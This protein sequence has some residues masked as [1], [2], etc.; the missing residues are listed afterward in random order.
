[1]LNIKADGLQRLVGAALEAASGLAG[2]EAY[3][4]CEAYVFDM[5]VPDALGWLAVAAP[6]YVRHSEIEPAP[7]LYAQAAGVWVDQFFQDWVDAAA[8]ERHLDAG[9]AVCL[10]S[11]ELHRRDHRPQW[12]RLAAAGLGGRPGF[13]LCTDFPDEAAAIFMGGGDAG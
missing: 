8:I 10:V 6:L 11:P 2:A 13:S 9:K 4:A 5:S 3:A 1:M 7:A 12:D